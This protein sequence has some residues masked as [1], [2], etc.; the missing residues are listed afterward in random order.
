MQKG[1]FAG[2]LQ[3]ARER[4]VTAAETAVREHAVGP[5]LLDD[6]IAAQREKQP[7]VRALYELEAIG[8]MVEAL[9][10]CLGDAL[11]QQTHAVAQAEILAIPGLTTTS[12]KA[13]EAYFASLENDAGS[14]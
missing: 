6:L 3:T 12:K 5:L 8:P 2:R 13:I 7:D 10:R 9:T 11:A 14:D 1:I 4:I